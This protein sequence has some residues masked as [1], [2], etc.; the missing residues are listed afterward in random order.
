MFGV[1]ARDP[2][3]TVL[4]VKA[5]VSPTDAVAMLGRALHASCA[6]HAI[7]LATEGLPRPTEARPLRYASACSGIDLAAVAM[8]TLFPRAWTYVFASEEADDVAEV[9]FTAHAPRGLAR[10]AIRPDEP[11]ARAAAATVD[12]P[13]VDVWFASPPCQSYSR[14]NHARSDASDVRALSDFDTM[15][16]YVR[17]HR[18]RA[19][20]TENV[21]EPASRTAITAALLS[22]EG[23]EWQQ[24]AADARLFGS[25]ARGRRF[26]MGRRA[27]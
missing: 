1:P 20:V 23:Y 13:P 6:A 27:P 12:A 4:N 10:D 8:D 24:W 18:P 14:R 11:D 25:M 15:L 3:H 7:A 5:L 2:L 17:A 16:D 26:W 21:D 19:V 22:V 9:L